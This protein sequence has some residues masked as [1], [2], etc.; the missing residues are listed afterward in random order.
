MRTP[1]LCLTMI[2]KNEAH[3]IQRCLESVR[4]VLD[5]WIVVDTGSTDNTQEVVRRELAAIPGELHERPWRDFA[6]NRNEALHLARGKADYVIVLDADDVLEIRPG[7]TTAA[8]TLDCYE[9]RIEDS[10]CHYVRANVFRSDRGFRYE[11]VVHEAL[12][13]QG[14]FT[15]AICDSIVYHR[16]GGGARSK[17]RDRYKKDASQLERALREDPRNTRNAYYLAQSL[18]DAGELEEALAAYRRRVAMGGWAEEVWRS[19][20]EVA[21]LL[22]RLERSDE[23]IVTAYLEAYDARPRRA[24]PLCELARYCRTRRRFALAHLFASAA[25]AIPRPE[26][27]LFLDESVYSWR[28]REEHALALHQTG[29]H[30]DAL[31][32]YRRLLADGVLPPS[33]RERVARNLSMAAVLLEGAPS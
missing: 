13:S 32:G 16:I 29:R 22:E 27:T 15:S 9:L 11:G 6:H 10:G 28:S 7:F 30:Q 24:E 25:I 19:R 3:V 21:L 26:D 2:V 18:R 12:V 4:R 14:P 8:L 5:Y 20:F 1:T 33:E 23:E 31:A 17:D